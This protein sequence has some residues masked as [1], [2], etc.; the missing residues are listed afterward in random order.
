MSFL[1]K[2]IPIRFGMVI[3]AIAIPAKVH[4]IVVSIIAAKKK[5]ITYSI[6]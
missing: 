3:R 6:L 1:N 5:P 4:M 2:K